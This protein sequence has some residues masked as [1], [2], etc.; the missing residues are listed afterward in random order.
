MKLHT[1]ATNNINYGFIP[2]KFAQLT[3][4][5]NNKERGTKNKL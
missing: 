3:G 5:L 1:G 4:S 2:F